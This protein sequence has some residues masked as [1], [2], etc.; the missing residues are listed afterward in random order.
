MITKH[1][2]LLDDRGLVRVSGTDAAGFLQGLITNDM[3]SLRQKGD[4]MAA[5]MLGPQGKILFEFMVVKQVD[6]FLLDGPVTLGPALVKR[7]SMYRLRA[8]VDIADVSAA[9]VVAAFWSGRPDPDAEPGLVYVDPRLE[10]LGV[11]TIA[12]RAEQ[13]V[14]AGNIAEYDDHR[15]RLGV[16]EIVKDYAAGEVFPHEAN[17]DWLNGVNFTKGCYVG[18]EVVSRMQHKAEIRKRFV[19][20]KITGATP[21]TGADI[22]AGGKSIGIM[23]SAAAGRG[24]A[25]LRFDRLREAVAA[26]SV[27]ESNATRLTP[28][29]PDWMPV[30]VPGAISPDVAS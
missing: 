29:Q 4:A 17:L 25:L 16:A 13:A 19:P 22:R 7:L 10:A 20:V 23:G 18:Q 28:E 30:E 21:E 9:L 1:A 11:R 27:L 3:H 12:P 15:R 6:G 2:A 5:A 26:G 14:L 8:A 24:L